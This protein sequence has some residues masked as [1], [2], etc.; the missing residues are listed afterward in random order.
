MTANRR[1][2]C[3]T[4]GTRI[5]RPYWVGT[6]T[7]TDVCRF[8]EAFGI[9]DVEKHDKLHSLDLNAL[10]THKTDRIPCIPVIHK[11]VSAGVPGRRFRSAGRSMGDGLRIAV[12]R[13]AAVEA[14]QTIAE[15]ADGRLL[16]EV[17]SEAP[18]KWTKQTLDA[19]DQID[20]NLVDE[21]AGTMDFLLSENI[22][23][24][25]VKKISTQTY[26]GYVYDLS[27]PHTRS[28]AAEGMWVHNTRSA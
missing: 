4:N 15:V 2:K 26:D 17:A 25:V 21:V 6:I 11:L 9:A 5:K 7:G 19:L 13:P 8:A 18:S 23:W 16:Q 22:R 3:A 27:V 10:R 12:T 24:T 1:M 14:R 28:Y 20:P